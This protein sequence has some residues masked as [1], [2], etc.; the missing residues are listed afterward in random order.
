MEPT[1]NAYQPVPYVPTP[2]AAPQFE[3]EPTVSDVLN[4]VRATWRALASVQGLLAVGV[5]SVWMTLLW[6]CFLF[7]GLAFC[8]FIWFAMSGVDVMLFVY[9]VLTGFIAFPA[10]V[11]SGYVGRKLTAAVDVARTMPGHFYDEKS[12]WGEEMHAYAGRSMRWVLMLFITAALVASVVFAFLVFVVLIDVYRVVT[13]AQLV[14]I[15]FLSTM[16]VFPTVLLSVERTGEVFSSLSP[17]RMVRVMKRDTLAYVILVSTTALPLL[18]LILPLVGMADP[19]F[20]ALG[21]DAFHLIVVSW[22]VLFGYIA[23]TGL[24]AAVPSAAA[25]FMMSHAIGRYDVLTGC[26]DAI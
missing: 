7:I 10:L 20:E 5:A 4:E 22:Q 12:L 17:L 11:V 13:V 25:L 9:L 26:Q 15:V 6:L 1:P 21:V 18:F 19:L 2:K 14:G 3:G 24:L 8:V 16:L 23:L